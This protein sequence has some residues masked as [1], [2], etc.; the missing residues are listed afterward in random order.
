LDRIRAEFPDLSW[1]TYKAIDDGWDHQVIILDGKLVFRFPNEREYDDELSTEI[2]VLKYLEPRV[3]ASIPNYTFI[4][5]SNSFAGYPIITGD[6]LSREIFDNLE[7]V[8][9]SDVADQLSDL[10]ST[11]HKLNVNDM[12]A[13]GVPN[14]YVPE[15]QSEVRRL[16]TEN[17]PS[18]LSAEDYDLVLK[19][20]AAVD[21]LLKLNSPVVYTHGDVY[22]NH[23]IWDS[24]RNKLGLIDFSDMAIS[25]PA[26]D[27]AELY[28]YGAAFVKQV[29]G[30]YTGLKDETFLERAWTYQCW[31]AVYMMTDHFVHQKTSF[32]VA[33]ETFDRVKRVGI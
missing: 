4:P 13:L 12:K 10:L 18:L 30:L 20:L 25:D 32:A 11:L 26:I 14:S 7:K 27:F 28:E 6:I 31:T 29:Y 19:V 8:S 33:R 5:Q 1:K 15:E 17:L 23:L 9:M 16:A 3:K 21:E 22:S 2:K 24:S